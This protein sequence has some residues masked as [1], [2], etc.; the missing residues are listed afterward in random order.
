M[1]TCSCEYDDCFGCSLTLA[2]ALVAR[3][4]S[5]GE[6]AAVV[7]ILRKVA[8]LRNMFL[9]SLFYIALLNQRETSA[10]LRLDSD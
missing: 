10:F 9:L 6:E 5:I 2:L 3:G 7:D 8:A 4:I 1:I